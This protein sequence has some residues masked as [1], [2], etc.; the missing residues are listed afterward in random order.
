[1]LTAVEALAGFRYAEDVDKPR[2]GLRFTRFFETYFPKAY[3]PYVNKI[4]RF[5]CRMIHAFS[6]AGFSL[7]HYRR[8]D[9]L[10]LGHNGNPLLN[11][12]NFYDELVAAAQTYFA[13]LRA[14]P[15]LRT[16]MIARLDD[17]RGGS[18]NV[19][20]IPLRGLRLNG[21]TT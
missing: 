17:E 13:E 8:E 18:I 5:R 16:L 20:P 3:G 1:M 6:P 14:D 7:T 10:K 12:E 11:A 19:G 15:N 21:A 9:H 2:E 4:W